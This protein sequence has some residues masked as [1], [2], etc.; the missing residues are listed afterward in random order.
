M[1]LLSRLRGTEQSPEVKQAVAELEGVLPEGWRFVQ[2]RWQLFGRRP[3]KLSACGAT[4]EGPSGQRV[5]AVGTDRGGGVPAVRALADAVAGRAT[6][7]PTWAPPPI[8]PREGD[9]WSGELVEPGTAE[10]AAAR[11]AALALLP[12][13]AT[14]MNADS[15]AFGDVLA[16]AAV[17]QLA[18]GVGVAGVGLSATGA[19]QALADRLRGSLA[20][21]DVWVPATPGGG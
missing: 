15:E 10:E 21:T 2:F 9:R 6:P 4:A 18:D 14:P 7:T 20:E 13:G 8:Q 16:W 5:L 17:V 12:E 11:S 19:W 1:G 3:V